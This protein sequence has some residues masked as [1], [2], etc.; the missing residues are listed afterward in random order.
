[1]VVQR[2]GRPTTRPPHRPSPSLDGSLAS[3]LSRQT[4]L[5]VLIELLTVVISTYKQQRERLREKAKSVD[6]P[7]FAGPTL[8]RK[9]GTLLGGGR[10]DEQQGSKCVSI[11]PVHHEK[12]REQPSQGAGRNAEKV[13]MPKEPAAC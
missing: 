1:M 12:I 8:V 13:S 7:I 6:P 11:L 2:R 10:G 5:P 9:F 4:V 3:T